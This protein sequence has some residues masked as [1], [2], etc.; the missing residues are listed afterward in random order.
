[1]KRVSLGPRPMR[2]VF[3]LLRKIANELK[4]SGTY[5]A[6]TESSLSYPEINKWF[7]RKK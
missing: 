5:N 6:M 4:M 3:S 2:A 1:V 7:K